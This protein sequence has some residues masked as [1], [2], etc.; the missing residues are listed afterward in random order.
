MAVM[1]RR[2][3]ARH[4][5]GYAAG[6]FMVMRISPWQRGLSCSFLIALICILSL[7]VLRFLPRALC[8]SVCRLMHVLGLVRSV[9]RTCCT[10]RWQ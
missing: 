9:D 8:S 5:T 6:L 1:P 4:V 10:I 7:L 2:R 3:G